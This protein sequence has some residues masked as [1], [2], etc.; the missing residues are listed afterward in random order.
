MSWKSL[1][2]LTFSIFL[3]ACQSIMVPITH[4]AA[5]ERSI[6][7]DV[8]SIAILSYEY[9]A[10]NPK[11]KFLQHSMP[12]QIA[13]AIIKYGTYNVVDRD[14]LETLITE[15]QINA[16]D[17]MDEEEM[18]KV[19]KIANAQA[20]VVGKINNVSV[21]EH[22]EQRE[23]YV[24]APNPNMPP[25]P[26]RFPYLVRR[27][28]LDITSEML[29]IGTKRRI[30]TDRFRSTYD[31]EKDEDVVGGSGMRALNNV[32][33]ALAGGAGTSGDEEFYESQPSRVPAISSILT[34][35][36]E[37]ASRNFIDKISAH[38]HSFTV[39]LQ[40][41]SHPAI[42]TGIEWAKNNNYNRAAE[43]F[44]GA[45]NDPDEAGK[46][47]YNIGVCYEAL[48]RN[49][50]ARDAYEKALKSGPN[51]DAMKAISRLQN[52]N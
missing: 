37:E 43:A 4:M 18:E 21:E 3:A 51:S 19:C 20:I 29:H 38:P 15:A 28:T 7:S 34:N 47:W 22:T 23:V 39:S 40:E 33:N 36:I 5:A 8:R 16:S 50:E 13:D 35:L 32:L 1:I 45:I 9:N 46:A 12:D 11:Y 44:R 6:P 14:H 48:G 24:T 17:D 52:Y 30:V 27:V 25:I 41:G 10:S 2:F 42:K 31:S 49:A 26:K